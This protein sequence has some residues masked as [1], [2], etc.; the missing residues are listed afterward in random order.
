[1]SSEWYQVVA[2]GARYW[3]A[4]LG[5][6]IIWRA[7]RWQWSDSRRRKQVMRNLPDAGYIGTLY[8]LE[9]ESDAFDEG[10]TINIPAE[11]VLGSAMGCDVFIPHPSVSARHMLFH[12]F[13]DGLHIR[14]YRD[15]Q[16]V[17]DEEV[18]EPGEQAILLHGATL[19]VGA[20]VLQLRLFVGVGVQHALTAPP[21]VPKESKR[22][23]KTAAKQKET[24]QT[25]KRRKSVFKLKKKPP[26][27]EEEIY[28]EEAYEEDAYDEAE[29]EAFEDYTD[30]EAPWSTNTWGSPF[31]EEDDRYS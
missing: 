18:L 5:V 29:Y 17:V 27:Q 19:T 12:L 16:M 6:I 23:G 26:V 13:P 22:G 8:V 30:G 28:D 11:G 24:V 9:G 7:L 3:F 25:E 31:D 1:M 2:L 21:P 20:V 10:D 14:A 15:Q 4:L